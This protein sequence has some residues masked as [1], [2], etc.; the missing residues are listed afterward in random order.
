MELKVKI[1]GMRETGNI[2]EISGLMPDY[3]GFIFY[4]GSKR[5][6][7]RLIPCGTEKYSRKYSEGGCIC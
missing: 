4:P 2:G 6:A 3:L 5:Y 7:G 1:C